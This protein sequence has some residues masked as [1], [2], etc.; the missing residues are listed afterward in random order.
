VS[1]ER[2]RLFVAL[3][4]PEH[5]REALVKWRAGA[6]RGGEG[7]RLIAPEALHVTLCFLGWRGAQEIEPIAAACAPIGAE[8]ALELALG[9]A[10]W[11][12]ARRPRVLAVELEDG[13]AALARVQA[14]VSDALQA[15]GW[16]TP[17]A[18]PFLG[19]VT[20]TR[21]RSGAR[22]R[23]RELPA[24][25]RLG[26]RGSTVSLFRSVL[27]PG[28]ARYERLRAVRLGS[29]GPAPRSE[30]GSAGLDPGF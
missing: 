25:P 17:E 2:V 14:E 8:P 23:A 6:L 16:Y 27:R 19:H 10:V 4:L 28:G 15:G 26:F 12:P 9:D 29:G 20:V 13:G 3:E 22:V 5:V 18:R 1:D 11:L 21:V 30:S 24:P 7:L